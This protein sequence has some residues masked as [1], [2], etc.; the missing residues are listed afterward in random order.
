MAQSKARSEKREPC[1]E[2]RG[3]TQ[4]ISGIPAQGS[5]LVQRV[6]QCSTVK[7]LLHLFLYYIIPKGQNGRLL[8]PA[9]ASMGQRA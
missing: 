8:H 3:L 6:Q 7:R 9:R 2:F 5:L 1:Y 4:S